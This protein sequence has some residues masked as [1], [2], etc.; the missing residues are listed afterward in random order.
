VRGRWHLFDPDDPT[1]VKMA[2]LLAQ[3]KKML[4]AAALAGPGDVAPVDE[5]RQIELLRSLGYIE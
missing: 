4:T 2:A 1:H 3:Y 5:E